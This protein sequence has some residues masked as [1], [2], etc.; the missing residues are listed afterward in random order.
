MSTNDV[1][2]INPKVSGHS[3]V[4]G[5]TGTGMSLDPEFT[6]QAMISMS[7]RPHTKT[8]CLHLVNNLRL[9]QE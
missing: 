3:I 2:I 8:E 1:I 7:L 9:N 5:T 4:L 6:R